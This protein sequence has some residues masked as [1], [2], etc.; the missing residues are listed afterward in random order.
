MADLKTT[1]LT[2]IEYEAHKFFDEES[3]QIIINI[4]TTKLKDYIVS[5]NCTDLIIADSENERILKRYCA[6]LLVDG[7]SEKT[8]YQYRQ[9]CKK[10]AI[11]LQKNFTGMDVYDIRY[12]LACE[13]QNGLSNRSL[14][15]TR[16]NLSAFFQWLTREELITKNPCLNIKPIK[17]ADVVRLP[18][19]DVEIDKIRCNCSSIMER[20]LI[21]LLLSSGVRVSE[22]INLNIADIDFKTLTVTVLHGKGD[23]QRITYT[24]DIALTYVE[25]YLKNRVTPPPSINYNRAFVL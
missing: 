5:E 23:K 18:F 15:N 16:A 8:I 11:A 2:D 22:L 19:S 7:K 10:L 17:Y 9:S 13:K 6:C 1:L 20:A 21:E 3:V 25:E 14:E 4:V 24:T 12:Y